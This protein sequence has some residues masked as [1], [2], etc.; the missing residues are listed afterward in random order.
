MQDFL[1]VPFET[2]KEDASPAF[3]LLPRDRYEAEIVSAMAGLTKNGK[4]YSVVLNWSIIEGDFENRTLWQNILIQHESEE[5]QKFG[6]QKFK[7]VLIAL[8]IT[9]DVTDL[10]VMCNKPCLIGV[11][12]RSDKNG[13]YADRNE[14]SR[15]MPLPK[16]NG[17]T[18]D[19]IMEAQKTPEAFKPVHEDL[20]DRIPF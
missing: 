12:V 5:A 17:P 18:R 4:G 3:A 2:E 20:N 16:H 1:D 6:R 14:I 7:D 9:E 13:Q 19:L 8:G 15:V 11:I 10:T